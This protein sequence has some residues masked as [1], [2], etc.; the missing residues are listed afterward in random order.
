VRRV[1]ILLLDA[2]LLILLAWVGAKFLHI[3]R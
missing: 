1:G 2:A 3:I